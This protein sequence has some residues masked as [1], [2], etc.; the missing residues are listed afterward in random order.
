MLNK[1]TKILLSVIGFSALNALIFYSSFLT[2]FSLIIPLAIFFKLGRL[3]N[4]IN[5]LISALIVWILG[6]DKAL[7]FFVSFVVFSSLILTELYSYLKNIKKTYFYSLIILLGSYF[8]SGYMFLLGKNVSYIEY[9]NIK[10]NV[11][12]SFIETQSPDVFTQMFSEYGVNKDFIINQF[13]LNFPGVFIIAFSLFVFLNIVLSARYSA[14][15]AK[16]FKALNI[17]SYKVNA[18]FVW[19]ALLS[20]AFYLF[21]NT[22]FTSSLYFK[23]FAISF[24]DLFLLIYFFQG[25]SVLLFLL[26]RFLGKFV[27]LQIFII[28][29]LA[30]SAFSFVSLL[31]F[32]DMF[33]DIRNKLKKGVVK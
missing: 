8:L 7:L 11:L 30:S 19:P 14:S 33:F 23:I 17:R 1:E 29:S 2:V 20:G 24:F 9:V 5:L 32:F 3:N 15:L 28:F 6:G 13:L 27:F 4:Y 10:V 16:E 21:A 31:G 26:N 22:E 18:M 12:I 25:T